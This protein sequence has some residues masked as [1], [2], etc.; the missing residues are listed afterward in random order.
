[1]GRQ[2]FRWKF[3]TRRRRPVLQQFARDLLDVLAM[4]VCVG[5]CRSMPSSTETAPSSALST[6]A[7]D[8]CRGAGSICE[9][10]VRIFAR[11]RSHN[12]RGSRPPSPCGGLVSSRRKSLRRG[13]QGAPL[14]LPLFRPFPSVSPTCTSLPSVPSRPFQSRT[15]ALLS[16]PQ[17]ACSM[18]ATPRF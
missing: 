14:R 11:Q 16:S 2:Y 8:V 6:A 7:R 18:M 10:R 1:M 15:T 4:P 3:S 5:D 13:R 12:L 17:D 9:A